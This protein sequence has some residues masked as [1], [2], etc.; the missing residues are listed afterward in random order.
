MK[1]TLRKMGNST[2]I[3]IP[4]TF[5][6][7]LDFESDDVEMTIENDAIVIRKPVKDVRLGWAEAS[8][9]L[10]AKGEDALQWPSF[11]NQSS[12]DVTW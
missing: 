1:T 9:A 7:E 8:E 6:T 11:A 12:E 2:G 4:K 3:I 10:T 5:L